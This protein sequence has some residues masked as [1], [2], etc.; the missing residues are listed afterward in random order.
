MVSN[1]VIISLYTLGVAILTFPIMFAVLLKIKSKV[2]FSTFFL[3]ILAYLAFSLLCTTFVHTLFLNPKRPTYNFLQSN[4]IVYSLYNAIVIGIFDPLG[5]YVVFKKIIVSQDDKRTSI[6]YA[7]GHAGTDVFIMCFFTV[8]SYILMASTL[9][10]KGM[11]GFME[12][13]ADAEHLD[14]EAAVNSIT[15]LS[16]P[17][18]LLVAFERLL[19][20]VMYMSMS[21]I[22]FYAAKRN[23]KEY[24]WLGAALR[25]LCS[26]PGSLEKFSEVYTKGISLVLVIGFLIIMVAGTAYVALKLYRNYDS[27]ELLSVSDLFRKKQAGL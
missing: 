4:A 23:M 18:I 13:Y 14:V 6:M 15:S 25:G 10:A 27:E 7:F 19:Y 16:V 17:F 26:I 20:F 21:V 11:E 2:R 9:N 3:G 22:M 1:S 24:F 12:L 5:M 8:I